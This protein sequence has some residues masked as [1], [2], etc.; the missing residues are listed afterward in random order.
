MMIQ[1]NEYLDIFFRIYL[2]FMDNLAFIIYHSDI[3][4]TKK[5]SYL[6]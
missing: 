6:N 5:D 3:T 1:V 2:L 4:I